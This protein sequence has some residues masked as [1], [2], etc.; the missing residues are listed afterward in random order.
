MHND[1]ML[2]IGICAN[3]THAVETYVIP[4]KLMMTLPFDALSPRSL[5]CASITP[6]VSLVHALAPQWVSFS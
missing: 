6:P 4:S 3:K 1:R 2:N 5:L